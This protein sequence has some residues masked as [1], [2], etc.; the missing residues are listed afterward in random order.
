MLLTIPIALALVPNRIHYGEQ[1]WKQIPI[2]EYQVGLTYE[3]DH[4]TNTEK[5]YI[6]EHIAHLQKTGHDQI[7][8]MV[9]T[10]T[11]IKTGETWDAVL[12]PIQA[13]LPHSE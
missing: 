9:Q 2:A 4:L 8:V 11:D 7:V 12:G 5:W 3:P 6:K 1:F 10:R 13:T